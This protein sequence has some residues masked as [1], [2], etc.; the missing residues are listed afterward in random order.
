VT[1]LAEAAIEM[2][3]APVTTD[4]LADVRGWPLARLVAALDVERR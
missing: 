3:T 2:L 1:W 4:R